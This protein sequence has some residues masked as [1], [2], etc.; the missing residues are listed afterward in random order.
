M[1]AISSGREIRRDI[2]TVIIRVSQTTT[3]NLQLLRLSADRRSHFVQNGWAVGSHEARTPG[4]TPGLVFT[5]MP[6]PLPGEAFQD[7]SFL[8]WC[9]HSPVIEAS[10]DTAHRMKG[11]RGD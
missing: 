8:R 5:A 1:G 7:Q 10:P 2:H 4:G 3:H 11:A 6:R 9:T